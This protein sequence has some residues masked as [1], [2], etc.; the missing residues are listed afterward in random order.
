MG[1][2]RP[3][4]TGMGV[5][6]SPF[7][8]GGAAQDDDFC[9]PKPSC[10]AVYRHRA[11]PGDYMSSPYRHLGSHRLLAGRDA[12]KNPVSIPDRHMP[13]P[14]IRLALLREGAHII[15]D[16][17]GEL[18]HIGAISFYAY[19]SRHRRFDFYRRRGQG[20]FDMPSRPFPCRV[21]DSRPAA[22][23]LSL[24]LLFRNDNDAKAEALLI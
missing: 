1:R 3:H 16:C 11:G 15:L 13:P 7:T 17:S 19:I 2:S 6:L 22:A 4:I 5:A 21:S 20:E 14:P 8:I 24:F 9:W 18:R 12:V 10:I 23:L